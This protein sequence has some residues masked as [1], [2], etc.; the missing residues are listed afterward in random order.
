MR[1]TKFFPDIVEA[2]PIPNFAKADKD[3]FEMLTSHT[4]RYGGKKALIADDNYFKFAYK[5][6]VGF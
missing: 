6:A 4:V 1:V 2:E 3:L 5:H